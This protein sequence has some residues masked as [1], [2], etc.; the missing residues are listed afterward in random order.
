MSGPDRTPLRNCIVYEPGEDTRLAVEVSSKCLGNVRLVVDVGTGTGAIALELAG[1]GYEV[2]GT[3][4]CWNALK[5]AESRGLDVVM[6]STLRA[7]RKADAVVSNPPY[8]SPY[9]LPDNATSDVGV[10]EE[11]IEEIGRLKPVKVVVVL[12]SLWRMEDYLRR[13]EE[14]GYS[15]ALQQ[16]IHMFFEDI[17]ATCFSRSTDRSPDDP[18]AH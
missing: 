17:V 14:L 9:E 11:L 12:S 15:I 13:I 16:S 2:I 5:V 4:V 3:D 18:D 1:L 7:I 6:T 8:L 10:V